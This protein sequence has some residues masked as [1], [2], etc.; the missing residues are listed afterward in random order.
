MH[1][2]FAKTD[3]KHATALLLPNK[4]LNLHWTSKKQSSSH[5][6]VPDAAVIFPTMLPS[7][8][9]HFPTLS[10]DDTKMVHID[11]GGIKPNSCM[12]FAHLTICDHFIKTLQQFSSEKPLREQGTVHKAEDAS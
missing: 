12:Y 9:P 2:F 1:F 11:R 7:S 8:P 10:K 3:Y 6:T 4:P 5:P